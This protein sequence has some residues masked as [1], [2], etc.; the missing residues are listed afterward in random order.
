MIVG[1]SLFQNFS[2]DSDRKY[3]FKKYKMPFDLILTFNKVQNCRF[4]FFY[5]LFFCFLGL[6]SWHMEV[7]RLQLLGYATVT[8]T[9][10]LSLV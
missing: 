7:P 1:W 8:A 3:I 5:F 4:F 6:H 2:I 10:D 9:P